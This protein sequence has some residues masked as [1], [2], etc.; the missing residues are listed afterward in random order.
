MHKLA[1][2]SFE[3]S[4]A[5]YPNVSRSFGQQYNTNEG[6]DGLSLKPAV[7]VLFDALP[8]P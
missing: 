6:G 4:G 2:C 7:P 3:D 5:D 8:G 1:V